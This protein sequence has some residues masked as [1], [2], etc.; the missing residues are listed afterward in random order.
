M[1]LSNVP[2]NEFERNGGIWFP[3]LLFWF[4]INLSGKR[5]NGNLMNVFIFWMMPSLSHL[6]SQLKIVHA[7]HVRL[8]NYTWYRDIYSL[9]CIPNNCRST[10]FY[11]LPTCV[12]L[13]V[14]YKMLS[15]S[16]ARNIAVWMFVEVV[17]VLYYYTHT[18]MYVT[19]LAIQ[20]S[21]K[22]HSNQPLLLHST[23]AVFVVVVSI[24]SSFVHF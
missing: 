9:S 17:R 10:D 15:R 12:F 4:W 24:M 6:L 19:L 2:S 22:A 11:P 1:A 7:V 3:S 18:H 16:T 23:N 13:P 20:L 21:R 14:F 5:I 8:S